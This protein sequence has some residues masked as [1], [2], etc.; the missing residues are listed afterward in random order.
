MHTDARAPALESAEVCCQARCICLLGCNCWWVCAL[1]QACWHAKASSDGP[2]HRSATRSGCNRGGSL[3]ETRH[4]QPDAYLPAYAG[5]ACG[6]APTGPRRKVSV[7]VHASSAGVTVY[8]VGTHG[9][10][11]EQNA[12]AGA[13]SASSDLRYASSAR[14]PYANSSCWTAPSSESCPGVLRQDP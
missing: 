4:A 11:D 5:Q 12:S 1:H 13:Y 9:E 8:N 7:I 6:G 3:P 10:P 2:S 14:R